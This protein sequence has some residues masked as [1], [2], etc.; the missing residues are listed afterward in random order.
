MRIQELYEKLKDK[1]VGIAGCGGLGSNVAQ[2]LVRSGI[3]KL[4]LNKNHSEKQI[5]NIQNKSQ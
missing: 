4:I 5:M 3:R 1:K 2:M